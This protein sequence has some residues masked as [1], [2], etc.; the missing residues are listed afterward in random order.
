[1]KGNIMT[2]NNLPFDAAVA[3]ALADGLTTVELLLTHGIT[4][5][6]ELNAIVASQHGI[7]VYTRYATRPNT[8]PH[9]INDKQYFV[10]LNDIQR[11][12]TISQHPSCTLYTDVDVARLYGTLTWGINAL[13][14][15]QHQG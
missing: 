10:I 2:N 9:N 5:L 8:G 1:M 6:D 12:L 15:L 13:H 7:D 14:R 3:Y 4:T 11:H